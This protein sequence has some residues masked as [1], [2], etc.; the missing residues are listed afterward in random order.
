AKNAALKCVAASCS[1]G[2]KRTHYGISRARTPS[3]W[4]G[5]RAKSARPRSVKKMNRCRA[6]DQRT[7]ERKNH[8]RERVCSVGGIHKRE[9]VDDLFEKLP[10]G[11]QLPPGWT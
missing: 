10:R 9:V 11:F 2:R 5:W 7:D 4:C 8:H 6:V 1:A 3:R